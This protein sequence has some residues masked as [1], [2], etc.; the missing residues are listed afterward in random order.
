[1]NRHDEERI[2][3]LAFGELEGTELAKV[4]ELVQ[5]DSEA[6]KLLAK[7][8]GMRSDLRL[9]RDV[10]PEQLSTD[11]MRDAILGQGLKPERTRNWFGWVWIPAGAAAFAFFATVMLRQGPDGSGQPTALIENSRP[12][13]VS[14]FVVPKFGESLSEPDWFA[15]AIGDAAPA[16]AETSTKTAPVAIRRTITRRNALSKSGSSRSGGLQYAVAEPSR[17]YEGAPVVVI[18][19]ERDSETGV[20]RAFEIDAEGMQDVLVSS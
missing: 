6:A 7:Y 9:L 16:V 1:M 18:S 19:S 20:R 4:Q 3:M 12:T 10:P 13:Y 17:P 2:A 15:D 8:E 14:D 11:R 5:R